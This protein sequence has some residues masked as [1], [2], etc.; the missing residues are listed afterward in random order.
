LYTIFLLA[1]GKTRMQL[2]LASS[3]MKIV[4]LTGILYSLL[5]KIMLTWNLL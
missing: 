4:M 1:K 3:L 5:V 2:H